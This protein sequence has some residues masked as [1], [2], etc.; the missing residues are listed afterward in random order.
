MSA[1]ARSG[2][3]V[4]A[5]GVYRLDRLFGSRN[6]GWYRTTRIRDRAAKMDAGWRFVVRPGPGGRSH[7]PVSVLD[8]LDED[9]AGRLRVTEGHVV[10]PGA[11]TRDLVDEFDA[12]RP[13][14]VQR[15]SDVVGR[16]RDVV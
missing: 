10:A 1:P 16:Q 15:P 2:A 3:R 9:A 4:V 12:G 5:L 7:P 8:E 13:G 14:V 11:A 6:D